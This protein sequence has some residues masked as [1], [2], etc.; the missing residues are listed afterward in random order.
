[1]FLGQNKFE[2]SIFVCS[3]DLREKLDNILGNFVT[4]YLSDVESK[5]VFSDK[6]I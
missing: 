3:N 5:N 2:C 4:G 1:M 6:L